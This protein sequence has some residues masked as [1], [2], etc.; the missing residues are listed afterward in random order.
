[1][2]ARAITSK[3]H[4]NSGLTDL[5]DSQTNPHTFYVAVITAATHA[6][7]LKNLMFTRLR[8]IHDLLLQILNLESIFLTIVT[9][10]KVYALEKVNKL[11]TYQY[12]STFEKE[13]CVNPATFTGGE[14]YDT[15]SPTTGHHENIFSH[16]FAAQIK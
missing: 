1:M 13:T 9:R 14:N 6:I 10:M 11:Y 7:V 8:Q 3:V 16:D 4:K 12:Q 5:S 15:T 2:T